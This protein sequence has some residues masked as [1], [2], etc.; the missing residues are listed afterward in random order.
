VFSTAKRAL[1]RRR[2]RPALVGVIAIPL[3]VAARSQWADK[4]KPSHSKIS[5][6][7]TGEAQPPSAPNAVGGLANAAQTLSAP[8]ADCVGRNDTAHPVFH[9]CIDWHSAVHGNYALRV[10]S[11]LTRDTKF[12]DIAQ[13][14]ISS[15]GLRSELVA[16]N[17]GQLSQELPYGFAWLLILDRE[18]ALGEM[19]PLAMAV[20]S[21][22]RRWITD[23]VE[24][25]E[26]SA[27]E[28]QNLSFAVFAI[29]RWYQRFAPK[30]AAALRHT[31]VSVLA[32][33]WREP[34]S[35]AS[36]QTNGF[37][38]PC[39]NLLLAL[40]DAHAADPDVVDDADLASVLDAVTATLP[41]AP[42][43]LPSVHA[44]GLNFSRSWA[45]YVAAIALGRK[46]LL[47]VADQYFLATLNAPELWRENYSSYSHWVAQFGIHALDLREQAQQRLLRTP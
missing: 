41:L 34:C 47:E 7:T 18:A 42:Q 39:A 40:S 17:T 45:I 15:G 21:Q 46:Q 31:V 43:D 14:V 9:G 13:S 26:L 24:G 36:R 37:F 32:K 8:I 16:V 33:R 23:H 38:D 5:S 4:R 19:A 29:H 22:L 35:Q 2:H 30:E 20:S 27:N 28:Y 25:S 44:A 3:L 11:R 12:V 6:S 10:I 1:R